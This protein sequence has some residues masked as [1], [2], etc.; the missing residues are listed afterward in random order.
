MHSKKVILTGASGFIGKRLLERLLSLGYNIIAIKRPNS[1]KAE[2]D[3]VCW[4]TCD[5]LIDKAD[6]LGDVDAIIHLAT[7]YGR[8]ADD[9]ISSLL[10]CNVLLPM[11]LMEFAY[12][13]GTQKFIST[14]SFFGKFEQTYHY[15]QSYIV[16]K[17][18]LNE[19]AR[20]YCSQHDLNFINMRLEHV[21]GEG[22]G[23]NKFVP[24]IINSMITNQKIIKC[25]TAQQKRDFVYIDD[26]VDAYITVLQSNIQNK[27]IEFE[28]GTGMSNPLKS[29]IEEL[30]KRLHSDIDIRYG[31]IP[32]RNDEIMDSKAN[33]QLLNKIGWIA[34]YDLCS[35]VEKMLTNIKNKR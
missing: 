10:E 18:H 21:Y 11:R 20:V 7:E 31:E 33:I 2:Q 28:V 32:L 6:E 8:K 22:D 29:I 12:Q 24:F 34:K 1:F 26:V 13:I 27:Y 5:E 17:R 16:S 9:D 4:L 23:E 30:K 14:D 35:G 15:M 3:S 25:T 19:L